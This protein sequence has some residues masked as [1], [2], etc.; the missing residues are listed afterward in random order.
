MVLWI[1]SL[2]KTHFI[3]LDFEIQ[4]TQTVLFTAQAALE[5]MLVSDS[6]DS[7]PR[8]NPKSDPRSDHKSN[9]RSD[10]KSGT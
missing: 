4:N 2:S 10:T 7:E 9:P 1:F 5:V 8:S 6:T 3:V